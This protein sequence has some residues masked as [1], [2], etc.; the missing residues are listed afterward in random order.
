MKRRI[1]PAVLYLV[2]AAAET[3][4]AADIQLQAGLNFDWWDDN[5]MDQARQLFTPVRVSGG[6]RD[7]SASV[8]T[9]YADTHLRT[10]AGSVSLYD[11]LDTK[12]ITSYAIAG[13]LPVDL[14]LGLDFNLPTGKTN[15]SS[16]QLA[17]IMDPD[18]ISVNNYG[19]GFDVNPTLT[20]VK[21]W[22]KWV[23]GVGLGYL[24]RGSYTFCSE[25]NMTGY[26]PG[27][28]YSVAPEVRYYFTPAAR[29]RL[30]GK[31]VW[32]GKDTMRGSDFFQEGDF[33]LFG[34][35]FDYSRKNEWEAD[36]T[37]R[38]IF[39]DK[40]KFQQSAGVLVTESEDVQGDEY[41]VDLSA[42]FFMDNKTT[43]K[44]YFQGRYF[45]KNGYPSDS[46]FFTGKREKATLGAE[47]T[48]SL[49]RQ[50]D[51]ALDIRT[52]LKHD[53][54]ANFPQIRSSRNYQGITFAMMLSGKF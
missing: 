43:V 34:I 45:T 35:G 40:S 29:A 4:F 19:E 23:A 12:V 3:S 27:Q 25:L 8:L 28:V 6:Y 5:R 50:L 46:Q 11:F 9:A 49:T 14:L 26:R 16:R 37:F 47:V 54:A 48:K 51:A 33:S 44:P 15:L 20:V 53:D 24:W 52:F 7:F 13:K 17:L 30:F 21:Q 1:L 2:L 22:K 32:Y 31:H 41:V 38:G 39:R 36:A 42:K 18:L 10:P